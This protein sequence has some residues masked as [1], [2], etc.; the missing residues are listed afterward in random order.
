MGRSRVLIMGYGA[1]GRSMERLLA[2][3]HELLVWERD[4]D[5][6]E[7]NI[8]L[9]AAARGRDAV[10]FTLPT[11][12]H[13]E[14]AARIRPHL[15]A[16]AVCLS[17]AKGL[18]ESART[19]AEIFATEF[20]RAA[21]WGVIYGPMI[22][23][24]LQAGKP[25]FAL[26]ASHDRGVYRRVRELFADSPL[27]LDYGDDVAGASWAVILKNVYVPLLG[28]AD[29]L[30]LGDNMRG[31]LL[32]DILA[33]IDC[34]A[35]ELGGR[36]GTAYGVAGLGDLVTTATSASSHH[37]R[38]GE[39]LASGR[40]DRMAAA[41]ANIRG[42]GIHTVHMLARHRRFEPGRYRLLALLQRILEE[43]QNIRPLMQSYL[44]TRFGA[45][46]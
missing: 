24:E 14:L 29:G 6:W 32:A 25:G 28:A 26:L 42:E 37:R 30:G 45:G 23:R 15:A 40:T 12:P 41:G 3:R 7:E 2:P 16:D 33:E 10:L 38:I 13:A 18:D 44:E 9:E 5:T 27:Y 20:G 46:P 36:P 17:I 11:K 35:V 8:P 19:P 22:A 43:P 34:L 1:M 4:L 39:D 21:G 31:F